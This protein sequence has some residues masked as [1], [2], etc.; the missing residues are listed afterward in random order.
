MIKDFPAIGFTHGKRPTQDWN[1]WA[2]ERGHWVKPA[3]RHLR[4]FER[5]MK[6]QPFAGK[7]SILLM[8]QTYV[9]SHGLPN[10]FPLIQTLCQLYE[11]KALSLVV[12]HVALTAKKP[13]S[14]L[15]RKNAQRAPPKVTLS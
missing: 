2:S 12:P 3:S 10:R 11:Q 5:W 1:D 9:L 14:F 7:A 15:F 4:R 8:A 13:M 6:K